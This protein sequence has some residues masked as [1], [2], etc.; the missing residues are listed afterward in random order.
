MKLDSKVHTHLPKPVHT[1][2]SKNNVIFIDLFTSLY[3]VYIKLIISC[4]T[5]KENCSWVNIY[6][7]REGGDIGLLITLVP[8]D[9]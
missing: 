6:K 8:K 1:S 9:L 7:Y 5:W 4:A 2:A 3:K